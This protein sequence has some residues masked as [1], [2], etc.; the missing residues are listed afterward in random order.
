MLLLSFPFRRA[1]LAHTLTHRSRTSPPTMRIL[2]TFSFLAASYTPPAIRLRPGL[3]IAMRDVRVYILLKSIKGRTILHKNQL[4]WKVLRKLGECIYFLWKYQRRLFIAIRNLRCI[5]LFAI[6]GVYCSAI[7]T[8]YILWKESKNFFVYIAS[9][10]W[11]ISFLGKYQSKQVHPR[12]YV[13]FPLSVWLV[14]GLYVR[15]CWFALLRRCCGRHTIR[16]IEWLLP[17]HLL[18]VSRAHT[19]PSLVPSSPHTIT[20][21]ISMPR[22]S[23][24][25]PIITS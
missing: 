17:R 9:Q 5:L 1:T 14:W 7:R 16:C 3:F 25:A 8:V 15:E 22:T 23:T 4:K 19:L 11:R 10:C 21:P 13:V 6:W 12:P 24:T 20:P 2:H 18:R